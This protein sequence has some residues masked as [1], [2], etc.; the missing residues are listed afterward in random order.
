MERV[1]WRRAGVGFV[2]VFVFWSVLMFG[3]G[4]VREACGVSC[5]RLRELRVGMFGVRLCGVEKVRVVVDA[6]GGEGGMR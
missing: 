2:G 1:S 5:S 3:C 4:G 6:S